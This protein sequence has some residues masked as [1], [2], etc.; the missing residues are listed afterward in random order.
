MLSKLS[1]RWKQ[2][3]L[4]Q[5]IMKKKVIISEPRFSDEFESAIRHFYEVSKSIEILSGLNN[6]DYEFPL[7]FFHYLHNVTL[8]IIWYLLLKV[9][10]S[11]ND[12]QT[13][14]DDKVD[15]ALFIAVCR[16]KVSE[17]LDFA[18]NNARAVI[19]VGIPFPNWKDP[20]VELKMKYNDKK[21]SKDENILQGRQWYEIQAFR[22]LNQALGRCIRHRKGKEKYS[23]IRHNQYLFAKYIFNLV[24]FMLFYNSCRLGSYSNG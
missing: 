7:D 1:E 6:F 21:R 17:G 11:T 4:W 3:G 22:A 19:C 10:E 20:K 16:G 15:G 18:D 5:N 9:I 23:R 14:E 24:L 13:N 2:T 12:L 8:I